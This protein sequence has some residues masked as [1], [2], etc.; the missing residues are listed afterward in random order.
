MTDKFHT[1]SLRG[2]FSHA[3]VAR[4]NDLIS[5]PPA[6]GKLCEASLTRCP[7]P[8]KRGSGLFFCNKGNE[9]RGA[10]RYLHRSLRTAW[11]LVRRADVGIGPYGY[12][13]RGAGRA[14]SPSHG[15]AV[16]APFRQGGRGD[17]GTDCHSQCAHWLRNDMVFHGCGARPGGG[18]TRGAVKR[19]VGEIGEAPPVAE[20][21][22]RFRGSAPI[23]GHN[24][25]RES[26]GTTVGNRRPLRAV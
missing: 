9:G 8:Q 3:H 5:L 15:F 20:E 4:E 2:I 11:W 14:E 6:G 24:S 18:V 12:I 19:G 7:D 13:A 22:S 26:V 23:G 25:G 1:G 16:P 10:G 21:A 17:G